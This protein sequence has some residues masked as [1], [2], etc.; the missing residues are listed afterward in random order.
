MDKSQPQPPT[1]LPEGGRPTTSPGAA[2]YAARVGAKKYTAPIGGVP[3]VPIPLLDAPYARGQTMAAQAESV[4]NVL[5]VPAQQAPQGSIFGGPQGANP[6]A[7]P[8]Q[9]QGRTQAPQTQILP[10][11]TLPDEARKDPAYREGPGSGYAMTNPHLVAKYGVIRNG[12]RVPPHAFAPGGTGLSA[13]T[14][15]QLADINAFNKQLKQGAEGAAKRAEDADLEKEIAGG[16][17]GAARTAASSA[18]NADPKYEQALKSRL[19]T[20][21]KF[22]RH[23]LEEM[24]IVDLLNNDEQK[25]LIEARCSLMTLDEYVMN[26][27]VRQRV[28]IVPGT[29]EVTFQSMQLQDEMQTRNLIS[30]EASSLELS[31]KYLVDKHGYMGLAASLHQIHAGGKD[32][33]FSSHYNVEGKFDEKLFWTKFEKVLQLPFHLAA[34]LVINFF[35]FEVRV[36]RLARATKSEGVA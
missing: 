3:A 29:F 11:D 35:W 9:A 33:L 18:G 36:R 32:L 16:P 13:E 21:D 8:P 27:F 2:A 34:S 26:G 22:D 24:G 4:R 7:P 23:R 14:A 1:V 12:T 19:E 15:Q 25:T 20:M 17:V 28:P 5:R 6:F 31:D 30:K 10:T